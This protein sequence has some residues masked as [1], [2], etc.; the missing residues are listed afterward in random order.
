MVHPDSSG[1]AIRDPSPQGG[2]SA[3]L[4]HL[5][6]GLGATSLCDLSRNKLLQIPLSIPAS[7]PFPLG[8]GCI[9][10]LQTWGVLTCTPFPTILP[11]NLYYVMSLLLPSI[12]YF[13]KYFVQFF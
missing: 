2:S 1:T 3:G 5:F 9:N 10:L 6:L 11:V 8:L 13:F 4:S 7:L 12:G